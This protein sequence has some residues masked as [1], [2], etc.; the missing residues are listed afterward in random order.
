MIKL[1]DDIYVNITKFDEYF[2]QNPNKD[3]IHCFEMKGTKPVRDPTSQWYVSK[4]VWQPEIYPPYCSGMAYILT[5]KIGESLY[6]AYLNNFVESPIWFEDVF[7]TGILARYA[8][9]QR[10]QLGFKMAYI[11]LLGKN[12]DFFVAHPFLLSDVR[13]TPKQR[14]ES[15]KKLFL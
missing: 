4:E 5:P 14:L 15:W 8:N 11:G 13:K 10:T 3:T 1:D 6:Q 9:V 7:I 2:S 12:L